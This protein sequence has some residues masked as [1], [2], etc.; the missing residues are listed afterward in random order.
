MRN[1][2]DLLKV[3]AILLIV[4]GHVTNHYEVH[5]AKLITFAIYIFHMPLFIAVS[6]AVHMIRRDKGESLARLQD[7]GEVW[8]AKQSSAEL[9]E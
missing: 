6:G 7:K 3:F 8:C 4:V 1:K 2:H 5:W 9:T